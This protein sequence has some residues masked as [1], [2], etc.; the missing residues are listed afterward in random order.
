M[1]YSSYIFEVCNLISYL[2]VKLVNFEKH[3][4]GSAFFFILSEELPAYY[5]ISPLVTLALQML[6]SSYIFEV[7]NLISY[8]KVKLVNFEKHYFG[9]A[10]FFISFD[11][12]PVYYLIS[13]LVTLDLQVLYSS[14]IFE[15]C[16]LISYLKVKLVNFEKHYFGSAFFF[17]L[18]EGLPA[19]YL[20]SPLVTL[21]LQML[22]SSYIF[23]VCN[24]ISYLKVKLVNFEKHYF[25]SAF[26]FIS[27]DRFPVY[28]LISPLVTL[29][30]QV[31]YNS[32]IFEVC[33]L[34]S[35]L[36][37]KLVNFEK[38]YF[39]SAFFYFIGRDSRL[40]PY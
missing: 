5:L 11:R 35:Y 29:D 28:Y 1:L 37:V 6:Y 16:N 4:F 3:Y 15:V 14:C 10:F 7:C 20:I 40:L 22:Y 19:Y 32:Y 2:K 30:L 27:F 21:A 36:K 17:I 38:H 23:E 31:L 12:F 9:S 26:F 34:I 24:L 39:G 25:G 18:S 8:L 33:N 13:P